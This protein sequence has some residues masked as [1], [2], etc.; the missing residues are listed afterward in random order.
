MRLSMT[1]PKLAP[2]RHCGG[3]ADLRKYVG[4]V[5][6]AV[7][8]QCGIQTPFLPTHEAIYRWNRRPPEKE[9]SS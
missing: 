4:D 9:E 5:A 8:T 6:I 3:K 7:F 2:C 1:D